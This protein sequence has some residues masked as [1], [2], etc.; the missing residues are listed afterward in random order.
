[1]SKPDVRLAEF[2]A[3]NHGTFSTTHARLLGFTDDLI[4]HRLAAGRWTALYLNSYRLAG[5]PPTWQGDLLAAC[6]AGGFRAVASHRSSA[7][8]WGLPGGRTMPAEITTPRWLRARHPS[9]EVHETMAVEGVDLASVDGIP[10]TSVE[11]TL[12]DLAAVSGDR[13]VELALDAAERRR[14]TT[15]AA[16][17]ATLM[18]LAKPGRRGV[19][20]LR[21]VL[22]LY[23]PEKGMSESEAERLLVRVLRENGLPAPVLQHSIHNGSTFVARVDAAYVDLKIAIEYDSYEH[24]TG[25]L[26]LVRDSARRNRLVSLGWAPITATAADLRNGGFVLTAAIRATARLAS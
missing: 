11:R 12:L 8:L 10:A 17:R 1:M 20:R 23:A 4:E 5:V 2:A 6:W 18:R 9:V 16:V 13:T 14:L 26:A 22:D 3:R 7:A 21:R 24:H 25:R 15:A 19:Q